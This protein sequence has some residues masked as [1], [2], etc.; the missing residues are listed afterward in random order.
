MVKTEVEIVVNTTNAT[1][2]IDEVGGAVDAAAGKF[3]NLSAGADGFSTVIDEATGGL[4][5]R[6]KNVA[7]GLS[8]MGKSAV[9][10]FRAA[11][12]GANGMK[13]ALISTGIGAIVVALG[14]IAA[15]WDD[16]VGFVSGASEEQ[17]DLLERTEATRDAAQDILTAT[18]GSENSL[19]LQGKSEREIR[20]LKI[21]QTNQVI[22]A[23][24]AQLEQQKSLKK[25]QVEAAERNQKIAAGII[26]FLSA[27]ITILLGAV[28]ALTF[29]LKQVGILEEATDLA[30][31]YAMGAA[32]LIGFDAEETEA[33]ADATIKETEEALRKLENQR[34]GYI[35]ANQAADQAAADQA[36]AD[37]KAAREAEEAEAKAH[38][39][40][41]LA[42][43]QAQEAEEAAQLE[44]MSEALDEVYQK[45]LSAQDQELNAIQEKYFQLEEFYKDDA[46]AAAAIEEQKQKELQAIQDKY[47]EEERKKD[48]ALQQA[49]VKLAT[50]SLSALNSLAQAALEG[51][52]KRAKTAFRIGKAL[53]LSQ[54]VINT[55]QAVSAALAQTTDVTPTQSLRFANAALAGAQGLAQILTIS[56]QQF[57]PSGG[58]GGG[59]ASVPRPSAFRPTMSFEPQGL[60][61]GIGLNESPNLG[62][63]IAESL[64]GSPIKA[65]VVSQE[66]QTQAKMNRKIRETA[67]IG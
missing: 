56:K 9:T 26:A 50:D 22:N 36:A 53:S 23:T 25:S 34:D 60:N 47:R 67:T 24:R 19:R 28:D 46:D 30:A 12:A 13:A 66:V 63:Q 27:P 42:I 11:I 37:A 17:L 48:A 57:N 43:R 21:Q 14:T 35:L 15:Y 49:K 2:S 29:G 51:N 62:N 58:A 44:A 5:T 32:S 45:Q 55:A 64:S 6:V 7:T 8:A 31:G 40:K 18:E 65:Y 16:I 1:K 52:D 4:A 59:T 3:E 61:S 10:S 39:E 54:A 20:D 38:A 41:M 33:E